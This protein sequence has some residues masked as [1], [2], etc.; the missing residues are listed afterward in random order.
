MTE[1]MDLLRQELKTSSLGKISARVGV[2][3]ASLSMLLNGKYPN[4]DKMLEKV[5]AALAQKTCPYLNETI[6]KE[7]CKSYCEM[8]IPI[9]NPA[10]M[11]HW[12]ACQQCHLK[13]V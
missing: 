7:V 9:N 4:P 3:K 8:R 11:Q 13:G 6:S 5:R 2:S 1:V 10:R 12:K